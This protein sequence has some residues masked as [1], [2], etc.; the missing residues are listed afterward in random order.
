MTRSIAPPTPVTG[1]GAVA[2]PAV[3]ATDLADP[4]V[5]SR[6]LTRAGLM[7]VGLLV[8]VIGVHPFAERSAGAA[9]RSA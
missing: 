2:A 6:H 4:P 3:G 8:A 5:P 7:P 9:R 1:R